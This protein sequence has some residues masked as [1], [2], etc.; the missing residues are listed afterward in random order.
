L[1]PRQWVK[2][3]L[4]QF[5]LDIAL[6]ELLLVLVEQPITV[7]RICQRGKAATG[8]AADQIDLA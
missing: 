3:S 4:E 7:E 2:E 1:W 6:E 8:N 5:T